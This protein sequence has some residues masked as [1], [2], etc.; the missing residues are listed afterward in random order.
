MKIIHLYYKPKTALASALLSHSR[1]VRDKALAVAGSV[2][3]LRPDTQFIAEAAMLHDLGIYKT[4]APGIHCRGSLPYICHGIIGSEIL[5]GFGLKR[6]AKVCERHIG[7]GLTALD[8]RE[9]KLALPLRDMQPV[10]IEEQIICYADKFYSKSSG[11]KQ[12]SI[13]TIVAELIPFG[14]DKVCR[15]L[16]WHERFNI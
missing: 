7:A 8:I 6:H 16:S 11:T 3:E 4:T 15:F 10:S 2:P 9:Q 14:R 13:K 12:L 5:E 1:L